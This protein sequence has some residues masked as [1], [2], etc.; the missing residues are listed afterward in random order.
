[1]NSFFSCDLQN[2]C[3]GIGFRDVGWHEL[4]CKPPMAVQSLFSMKLSIVV[5]DVVDDQYKSPSRVRANL[6]QVFEEL[7]NVS[8]L[9]LPTSR[10]RTNF[11][12]LILTVPKYPTLFLVGWLSTT[13]TFT[14]FGIHIRQLDPCWSNLTSS[15]ANISIR[16]FF[17][18]LSSFFI[19]SAGWGNRALFSAEG[20][21]D[22]N[23]VAGKRRRH[24]R[25]SREMLHCS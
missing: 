13:G 16:L 11:P 10:R 4:Q 9:N 2:L 6:A 5:F 21:G 12:S 23:R 22:E 25:T 24:C 3:N 17:K 14:S 19:L 20:C 8:L 18:N 1:M 7:K 15:K